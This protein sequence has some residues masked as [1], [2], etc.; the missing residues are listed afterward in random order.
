MFTLQASVLE[1]RTFIFLQCL[2]RMGR[3]KRDQSVSTRIK[4][5]EKAIQKTYWL[6][7]LSLSRCGMLRNE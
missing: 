6:L 7:R 5:M 3:L 4:K 2:I 1:F